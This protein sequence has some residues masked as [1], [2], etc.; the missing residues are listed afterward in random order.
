MSRVK[1]FGR[2][3]RS[4]SAEETDD[5]AAALEA[6]WGLE[7]DD[8]AE[9]LP[10]RRTTHPSNKQQMTTWFYRLLIVLFILLLIGLLM[11]GRHFNISA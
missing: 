2:K 9:P 6:E 3:Y 10:A 7:L 1:K 5:S 8:Q 11:W 4:K